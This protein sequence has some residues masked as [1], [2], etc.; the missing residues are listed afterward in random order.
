MEGG[1]K[2]SKE[3]QQQ[4]PENRAYDKTCYR[5]PDRSKESDLES[6]SSG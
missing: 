5:S 3:Q 4:D 1:D 2:A 6:G